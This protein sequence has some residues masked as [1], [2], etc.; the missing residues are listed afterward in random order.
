MKD[1]TLK[2]C[3]SDLKRHLHLGTSIKT[4]EM[5][6]CLE[7]VQRFRTR[8]NEMKERWDDNT[9]DNIPT[10]ILNTSRNIISAINSLWEMEEL[11]L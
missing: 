8:F 7:R 6:E 11:G 5:I 10:V 3:I 2:E 9:L 4:R 1:M